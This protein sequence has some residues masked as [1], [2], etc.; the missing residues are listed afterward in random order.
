[1]KIALALVV[2]FGLASSEHAAAQEFATRA[3]TVWLDRSQVIAFH[4]EA[5]DADRSFD[6]AAADPDLL[7]VLRPAEVLAGKAIGFLRVRGREL[8]TTKLRVA[9]AELEVVVTAANGAAR[10]RRDAARIVGPTPG[11]IVWGTFAV[12]VDV[13]GE[14]DVSDV[15]LR[16]P[17]GE[18]L[19]GRRAVAV[20]RSPFQHVAFAVDASALPPG[21]VELVAVVR[22]VASEPLRVTVAHPAASATQTFECESSGETA[23]RRYGPKELP[24]G[25]D[26]GA[27]GGAFI[28]NAGAYPIWTLPYSVPRN[29]RYQLVARARGDWGAGAFPTIAVSVDR[30]DVVRTARLVDRAWHRIPLGPPLE[31]EAGERRIGIRFGNDMSSAPVTDRNLYL[32]RV[33]L[34]AVDGP[35]VD[36]VEAG[37]MM[38]PVA[39]QQAA[40]TGGPGLW[41][42]FRRSFDGLPVNGLLEIG[43]YCSWVGMEDVPAPH[44]SLL[45]NGETVVRQQAARPVF[46]L[47][48]A[49]FSEGENTLQLVAEL[50]DGRV[51]ETPVQ[52]VH[53]MGDSGPA[54]ARDGL[55][56]SVH[57]ER[58]GGAW[59]DT[60]TTQGQEPG[61]SVALPTH[62][63]LAFL[64]LPDELEGRFRLVFEARSQEETQVDVAL[65]TEGGETELS[66][67]LHGW[68]DYKP[69]GEIELQPGPKKLT[70]AFSVAPEHAGNV[71][72]TLNLRSVILHTAREP[73][74]FAPRAAIAYPAPGHVVHAVDAV[75]VDAYDDGR[76]QS[77]DLLIDGQPRRTFGH[78]PQGAG[79][80]VLPLLARDLVPG[81]HTLAVRVTDEAGNLGQ[82]EEIHFWVAD[83]LPDEDSR[84]ARAVRILN[85]FGFGPDPEQL[86]R[87]LL[88]GER[89]WLRA[90]L[91]NDGAGDAATVGLAL[92]MRGDHV[93]GNY[94][95]WVVSHL[96]R[97]PNPVR[98]RLCA[99]IENHFSTYGGKTG[100]PSEWREHLDFQELAAAP[101]G[102][103]LLSSATSPAM[104]HYLDQA[105]SFAQRLNENYAREVMELHTVG[106]N[107]GYDQED[108]TTL[109]ELLCGLTLAYQSAPSGMGP[110]FAREFR[111]DP[112]LGDGAAREV[113]GMRFEARPPGERFDRLLLTLE[114]L[115][116]H[117]ST[118]RFVCTK[119]AEH[120]VAVPAPAGLVD[121]LVP[122]FVASGGDLTEVVAS[123]AEHDAFWRADEAR[124]AQP[125]DFA[126]RVAR[127]TGSFAAD[128]AVSEY[129]RQ[130]G[131]GFADRETP[132]GYPEEDEAWVDTNA[133]MQRWRFV[134][135]HRWIVRS[136][137][138]DGMRSPGAGDGSAWRQRVVDH[139]AVRL[140]GSTLS[141][142]SN[143]A[144]LD[145]LAQAEGNPWERVEETIVLLCRL[146][147]ASLK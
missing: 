62:D 16:L 54:P 79:Y 55:R 23:E 119:L 72:K 1:M 142:E 127:T 63:R 109:A 139:A 67:K 113:L 88:D 28:V 118:A 5:A 68:W 60:L 13:T 76:L 78:V 12:G 116:A 26:P 124:L 33:E 75:V 59:D 8:G 140:T 19:G 21:P 95:R 122:I 65:V 18:E 145:F 108:V 106:V 80:T 102:E 126:V 53:M 73:D 31:L 34:L 70:F 32:D 133:L 14:A 58:W 29:G 50:A 77:A 129:L 104:V 120:Y 45:L 146:P 110:Y 89:P 42:A 121:D 137:V 71:N 48:R 107:G 115:A 3:Q 22:G 56:F 136:L 147:E 35:S 114:M 64:E 123:I 24:V 135:R 27:S 11:A 130:S 141:A 46:A 87:I 144:A 105:Q 49:A 101:F 86:A 36:P 37:M 103:L 2:S 25:S 51:A 125:I 112:D 131:M 30:P 43:G 17:G 111:Y 93:N 9:S 74:R 52:T 94:Q 85:R 41:V 66:A 117:P 61:Q 44:V 47:D 100:Y 97:T 143:D 4:V 91:A 134:Q 10:I 132:D 81:E 96:L 6:T 57:D 39:E 99:W 138:P 15:R 98:A 82:S 69:G 92:A 20:H 84:Y 40:I 7:E 90:R 128:W 38:V 83:G